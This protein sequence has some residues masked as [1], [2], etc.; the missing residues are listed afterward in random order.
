MKFTGLRESGSVTPYAELV[1][2]KPSTVALA[3]F[4]DE[5]SEMLARRCVE[6]FLELG[7]NRNVEWRSSFFLLHRNEAIF[8]MLSPHA[9][10]IAT[11]LCAIEP[12]RKRKSRF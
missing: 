3:A 8:D 5:K 11:T 10:D 9:D 7:V 12:K 6:N 4:G 2:E 1:A